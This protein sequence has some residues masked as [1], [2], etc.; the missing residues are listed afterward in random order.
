MMTDDR[1]NETPRLP[2]V[3]AHHHLLRASWHGVMNAL[4]LKPTDDA[5]WRA[6]RHRAVTMHAMPPASRAGR[7]TGKRGVAHFNSGQ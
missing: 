1:T 7:S 2:I 6:R 5:S 3:V 4:W